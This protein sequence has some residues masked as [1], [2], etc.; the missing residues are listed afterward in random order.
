MHFPSRYVVAIV[1]VAVVDVVDVAVVVVVV[2]VRD[3]RRPLHFPSS[4][5]L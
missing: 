4:K 2:V 1:D 5:A 3:C